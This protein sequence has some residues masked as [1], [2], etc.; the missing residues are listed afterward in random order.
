MAAYRSLITKTLGSYSNWTKQ[1][2]NLTKNSFKFNTTNAAEQTIKV[3]V[4]NG[5][6]IVGYWL[7]GCSIMVAGAV[8][9]GGVTRLTESGL[10]MVDWRLIKDMLPPKNQQEWIDEF[11]KY[12]EFPEWKYHNKDRNMSL[13]DFK[14]IYYMEYA[15]R[16][17][18]RAIGLAFLIPAAVFWKKGFFNGTM[19]KRIVALS[20]L[21]GFQGFLGWYMVKSGLNEPKKSTDIPRVSHYRLAAHLGS[22]FL[23]YT[24]MLWSSLECIFKPQQSTADSMVLL[25]AAKRS[26]Y[27]MAIIFTTAVF[28]AFVAGLDAGLVYN[29]F[30]KMADRWIPT[31][32]FALEP[33]WTNFFENPTTVQFEHRILGMSTL[34]CICLFAL[35]MRGVPLPSRSRMALNS[36]VIMS[37]LQVTLGIC[38]LLYYVP[39]HLAATHQFGSLTL[40]SFAIWL[41]NELKRIPK[42]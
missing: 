27:L 28:G 23:L 20:S 21:L 36:L 24:G 32:L 12:K 34:A 31:D 13:S 42:V 37:F 8:V 41:A 10:S 16:M 15:H 29:S 6:K 30:P 19:K 7:G 39:T 26:H 11:E 38:T 5:Q 3:E 9:L 2:K 14:F 33:K 35:S 17:W 1:I 40:L 18:G 25:K 4:K 22:A